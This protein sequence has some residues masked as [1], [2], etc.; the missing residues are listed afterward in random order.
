MTTPF[1]VVEFGTY[2]FAACCCYDAWKKGIRWL[3][4]LVAATL[5]GL[6]AE[7]FF[8]VSEHDSLQGASYSYGQFVAMIGWSQFEVPLWVGLGW[9]CI[10]YACI[11]TAELLS[12]RLSVRPVIAGLLAINV[13]LSLDPIAEHFGFWKWHNVPAQNYYGVPFDNFLGWL[14]IVGSYTWSLAI[15]SRSLP[16]SW[17]GQDYWLP[18][19]GLIPALLVTMLGQQA[20]NLIYAWGGNQEIPFVVICA[21]ATAIAVHF[22]V[23]ASR[24]RKPHW[25]ILAL[26]VYFHLLLLSLLLCLGAYRALASLLVVI[27][28]S[29][30]VGFIAFAWPYLDHLF[31]EGES[32]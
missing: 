20:L 19:A 30:F 26:P 3:L 10:V 13:D 17:K 28:M 29:L 7:L 24:D 25:V 18:F 8:L 21:A 1:Y 12:P 31:P 15:L 11:W 23:R 2:L 32:T 27:P 22:G 4:V 14:L 16:R 9:G 6:G 5:F